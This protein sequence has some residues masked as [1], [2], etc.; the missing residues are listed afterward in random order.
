MVPKR[1]PPT[2]TPTTTTVAMRRT[3]PPRK[4]APTPTRSLSRRRLGLERLAIVGHDRQ[5]GALKNLLDA[6]HLLAA[7]LH[8]LRAHLLGHRQPLLRRYR[9]EPLRL[10][11]VDARL[12]VAQVGFEAD[13]D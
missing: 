1:Y 10:E 7:A 13:E 9:G 12:L 3:P 6:L 2:P 4:S 11:H 5:D 8:I